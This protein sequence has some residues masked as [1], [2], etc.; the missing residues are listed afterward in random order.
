MRNHNHM[1][2][3]FENSWSCYLHIYILLNKFTC[4]CALASVLFNFSFS[5]SP[6]FRMCSLQYDVLLS[7]QLK[8]KLYANIS[9]WDLSLGIQSCK[10]TKYRLQVKWH[11][12]ILMHT[13]ISSNQ[14][15]F[16]YVRYSNHMKVIK[17]SAVSEMTAIAIKHSARKQY[18]A[19][20]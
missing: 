5:F 10:N 6:L 11:L 9:S 20:L 19:K 4:T 14:S 12:E 1:L 16:T 3:N 15:T 17:V 13:S 7:C 2:N 18:A 8:Q